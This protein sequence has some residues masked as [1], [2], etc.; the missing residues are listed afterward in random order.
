[1][2]KFLLPHLNLGRGGL[3]TLGPLRIFAFQ[4]EKTGLEIGKSCSGVILQQKPDRI[5]SI[6][7]DIAGRIRK[8]FRQVFLR[9]L[10]LVDFVGEAEWVVDAGGRE[11]ETSFPP[12]DDVLL[13]VRCLVHPNRAI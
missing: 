10:P 3:V 7:P 12:M 11:S 6:R 2:N 4:M 8:H 5:E 9:E 13:D 1:M